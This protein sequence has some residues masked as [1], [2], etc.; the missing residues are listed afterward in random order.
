MLNLTQH[1]ATSTQ[2]DAGVFDVSEEK[3]QELQSLL[4]FKVPPTRGEICLRAGEIAAFAKANIGGATHA[5]IGGAPFL[6]S[7]LERA[8]KKQG[9]T[10]LYSFSVRES[11]EETSASGEV[12]KKSVFRHA[13][14]INVPHTHED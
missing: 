1:K 6:M 9:I 7:A 2:I 13:G 11:V 8:L 5:M 12:I 10:P 4:S 3:K 14:F